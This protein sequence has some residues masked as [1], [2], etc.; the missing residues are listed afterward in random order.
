MIA[1]DQS[2]FSFLCK[3]CSNTLWNFSHTPASFQSLN[4]RQQVIPL[5]HPIS[6]GRYSHPIP[7]INTNS[8]PVKALRSSTFFPI[9]THESSWLRLRQQWLD[10]FPQLF[11]Q[12][13]FRHGHTSLCNS[14][15]HHYPSQLQAFLLEVFKTEAGSKYPILHPSEINNVLI[16]TEIYISIN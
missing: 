11:A 10:D 2:I 4:R 6:L 8:I 3:F 14:F 5:L 15:L 12:Y 16:I 9:R 13:F 1:R 7:V